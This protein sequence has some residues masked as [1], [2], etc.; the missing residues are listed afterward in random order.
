MDELTDKGVLG[1]FRASGKGPLISL[2]KNI[3]NSKL[4]ALTILH[5]TR[6]LRHFNKIEAPNYNQAKVIW[7][8]FMTNN[9]KEI[10]ATSTNVWQAKKLGLS[11]ADMKDV[12][13]YYN[14]YR[15][16]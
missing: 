15:G 3:G 6:H 13:W 1:I 12:R 7:N 8:K 4:Y 5:E 16:N 9:A 14:K 11:A 2:N 10:F